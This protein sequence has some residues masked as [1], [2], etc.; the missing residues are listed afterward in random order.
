AEMIKRLLLNEKNAIFTSATLTVNQSFEFFTEEIGLKDFHPHQYILPSPFNYKENCR[1]LIP[2]DIPDIKKVKMDEY[3]EAVASHLI[4]VAQ[5]TKGRMLVLFTSYDML[6][7]TYD[8]MKDSGLLDDF[9]LMAQGISSGSQTRLTKNFQKFEKAI[10]F[11]TNSFW[12]GVDIPGE[13]LSCLAIV[14]LPFSPPDEPYVQAKSEAVVQRG[15]NPFS[16]YS[17]PQAILRFK[18]GFGRLIRSEKDRGIIIIFD[19][20]IETTTY[21]KAFIKS[22]P[23]VPV[24][25]AELDELIHFIEDWL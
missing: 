14:R 2:R 16:A 3:I 10:L 15:K 23:S 7:R 9:V 4:G 12:E 17:L 18:Q 21:G 6:R 20:R 25:Q 24:Q 5:A 19:R 11:G 13:D 8:L 22:V 1:I